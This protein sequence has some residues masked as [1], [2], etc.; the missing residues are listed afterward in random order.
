MMNPKY[1]LLRFYVQ[2][3][4]ALLCSFII[5]RFDEVVIAGRREC[6][7]SLHDNLL[8]DGIQTGVKAVDSTGASM[9]LPT[10]KLGSKAMFCRP[11]LL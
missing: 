4:F 2:M 8:F 7:F 5:R 3:L 11:S 9:I 10:V 6:Y 1:L